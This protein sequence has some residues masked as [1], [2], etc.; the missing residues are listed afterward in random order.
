VRQL[1]KSP[2]KRH[3]MVV[4]NDN[5]K[6]QPGDEKEKRADQKSTLL[7][8]LR[9]PM[10]GSEL[11]GAM[12]A[13]KCPKVQLRDIWRLL[14]KFNERGLIFCLTPNEGNGRLYYFTEK[15]RRFMRKDLDTSIQPLP[16]LMNWGKYSQVMRAQVRKLV[17]LHIGTVRLGTSLEAKTISTIRKELLSTHPMGLG[18]TIRAV[19]E[20]ER[21]KLIRRVGITKK[22]SRPLYLPTLV[23]K[24]IIQQIQKPSE[25][26]DGKPFE[27]AARPIFNEEENQSE[28]F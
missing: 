10:T 25:S 26:F 4:T 20:L 16:R 8:A 27:K 7:K 5:Q 21:Q 9:K 23:G 12:R 2:L 28:E 13:N 14:N 6:N 24:R 1:F 19:R 3:F 11:L 22:R 15:G 17:L 18:G